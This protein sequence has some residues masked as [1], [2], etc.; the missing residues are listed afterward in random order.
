MPKGKKIDRKEIDEAVLS[1]RLGLR[2]DWIDRWERDGEWVQESS[3]PDQLPAFIRNASGKIEI[4]QAEAAIDRLVVAGCN[5]RVVY[6]CL[7]QLS[8]AAMEIRSGTE[9]SA[10]PGKDGEDDS[11]HRRGRKLKPSEDLNKLATKAKAVR[12]EIHLYQRELLLAAQTN[13]HPLP[14]GITTRPELAEDTIALL[15]S[16]LSWI[17]KLAEGYAAPYET[18]LLKSKGLLYLTAY[19]WMYAESGKLRGPQH[20]AAKDIGAANRPEVRA[21]RDVHPQDAALASVATLC[22][23]KDGGWSP[24]ELYAKLDT[25]QTDHPRLYAL[26]Y[27]KLKELHDFLSR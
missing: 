20:L 3:A 4:A 18:T 15:E 13:V 26:L 25:F 21:R 17:V 11:V 10:E 23:G 12:K 19:V 16:S 9:W 5:R 6:F 14:V 8:P 24:S 7:E 2:Q 22:S 27:S 1:E